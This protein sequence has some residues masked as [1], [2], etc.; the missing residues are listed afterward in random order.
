MIE[1]NKSDSPYRRDGTFQS[2]SPAKGKL[3]QQHPQMRVYK[4]VAY[5]AKVKMSHTK[6]PSHPQQPRR[7]SLSPPTPP[8]PPVS[9]RPISSA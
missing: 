9:Q 7:F 6:A 3:V 4:P 8:T 2:F 1:F 5:P